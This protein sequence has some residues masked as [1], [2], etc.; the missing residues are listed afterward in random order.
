MDMS[1][2]KLQD[3]VKDRDPW[4]AAVPGVNKAEWM[5]NS[6][7]YSS[8]WTPRK[9]GCENTGGWPRIVEVHM[10]GMFQRPQTLALSHTEKS[11]GFLEISSFLLL[12][13]ILRSNCLRF[14]AKLPYI[15]APLS[16][17]WSGSRRLTWDAASQAWSPTTSSRIKHNLQLLGCEYTF[18]W[19]RK[20]Q[21]TLVSLSGKFHGPRSLA[22]YSP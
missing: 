1:L 12:T 22:G 9:A 14:V 4:R 8:Q 13:V 7:S 11:T 18:L 15:L 2:S 5:N 10:K 19:S 6:S 21:P 3:I 16:P 17:P 20:W